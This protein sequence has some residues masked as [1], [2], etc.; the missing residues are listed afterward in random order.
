MTKQRNDF[1]LEDFQVSEELEAL[2]RKG[3]RWRL[4]LVRGVFL[5]CVLWL[6]FLALSWL[7]GLHID[8]KSVWTMWPLLL[9]F[10]SVG[11]YA[12]RLSGKCPQCKSKLAEGSKSGSVVHYCPRC[13]I[14]GKTGVEF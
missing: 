1:I 6:I 10:A 11:V 2:L 14:Y 7:I 3:H 9:L 5:L 13:R 8:I 12:V 4:W